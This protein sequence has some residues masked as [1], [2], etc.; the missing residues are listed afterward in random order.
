MK[1]QAIVVG[2]GPSGSTAAF[3]LA[4][5]G[6]DVLLVDKETWPRNK[7][8]GDAYLPTLNSI[9]HDMGIFEELENE[10][11]AAC[12]KMYTVD[13]F[14]NMTQYTLDPSWLIPRRIGDDIIRRG[15]LRAGVDF[16]E[17]FE[18]K[19]L[20]IRRGVVKGI[21]AWYNNQ[22][23]SMEADAVVIADGAHSTLTRQLG[24][25]VED[26]II[27]KYV[28][29]GYFDNVENIEP[30]TVNQLFLPASLPGYEH[31]PAYIWVNQL[32]GQEKQ[33][34][35]G[36]CIPEYLFQKMDMSFDEIYQFWVN[37]TKYGQY[38]MKNAT[39]IKPLAGWRLPGC[40]SLNKCYAAGAVCV[41]DCINMPEGAS[42]YG[43][44]PGMFAAKV[45]GEVLPGILENGDFSEEAFSVF[46]GAI[47]EVI[48]GDYKFSNF[49]KHELIGNQER[50]LDFF[51]FSKEIPNYPNV[52]YNEAVMMYMTQKLG[53]DLSQGL[54]KLSQ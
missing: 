34:C 52:S 20:I 2:A 4:K 14:E 15:A 48:G 31:T 46:Q 43:I 8:C 54:P 47:D 24:L 3:Y 10:V 22:E 23:I 41:G 19:E 11:A 21:R 27:T 49:L 13:P 17:N 44:T 6:V 30:N 12:N 42:H 9:F 53:F 28:A 26:P 16:I 51:A 29:R 7:I 40:N 1:R 18:V 39:V 25:F 33:A 50:L 38:Y 37:N 36:I 45:I 35:L 5:A 32:Y